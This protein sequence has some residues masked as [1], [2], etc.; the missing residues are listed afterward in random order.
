MSTKW[1]L[2]AVVETARPHNI[3]QWGTTTFGQRQRATRWRSRR[4]GRLAR[5]LGAGRRVRR[6]GIQPPLLIRFSEILKSRVVDLN[7]AFKRAISEYGYRADYR[8]V[9]PIKVNQQRHVVERLVE[10]G[11][12]TTSGWRPAPSRSSSRS[13]RSTRTRK[14]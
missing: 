11:R 4:P 7:E 6:R 9:Y 5:P 2:A 12:P 10:A 1:M 14:P 3:R 13:W 8:G